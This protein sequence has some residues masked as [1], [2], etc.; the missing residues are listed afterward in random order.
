MAS[1]LPY[2]LVAVHCVLLVEPYHVG[3]VPHCI[4]ILSVDIHDVDLADRHNGW[5]HGAKS[6]KLCDIGGAR[7]DSYFPTKW[8]NNQWL[9]NY[10]SGLVAWG[11]Q[12]L[13]SSFMRL[14]PIF[15]KINQT[16]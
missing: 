3:A 12:G 6:K 2:I 16:N 10:G 11:L 7:D 15:S 13:P 8:G 4:F 5:L 9:M 1:V 14:V